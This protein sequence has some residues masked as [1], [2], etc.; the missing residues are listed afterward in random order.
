MQEVCGLLPVRSA[1]K[2]I[3]KPLNWDYLNEMDQDQ[4]EAAVAWLRHELEQ[5]LLHKLNI[6]SHLTV[7]KK[8]NEAFGLKHKRKK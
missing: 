7:V 1:Q 8:I 6:A 2:M 4:V 3:P 5:I